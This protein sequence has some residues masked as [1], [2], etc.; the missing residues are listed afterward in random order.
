MVAARLGTVAEVSSNSS[1]GLFDLIPKSSCHFHPAHASNK[2][3]RHASRMAVS[4][5]QTLRSTS[6]LSQALCCCSS[7][8]AQAHR[9]QRLPSSVSFDNQYDDQ[10]LP[11]APGSTSYLFHSDDHPPH[12]VPRCAKA[13]I[14]ANHAYPHRPSRSRHHNTVALY[15]C[16]VQPL[17]LQPRNLSSIAMCSH[18][19]PKVPRRQ[20]QSAQS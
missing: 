9:L 12:S 15:V 16:T 18:R 6:R 11:L 1:R 4:Y 7:T 17:S 8:T 5:C 3:Q 2:L 10:N 14:R 20:T 19:H 13:Y